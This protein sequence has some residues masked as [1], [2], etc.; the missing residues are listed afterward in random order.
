MPAL[1]ALSGGSLLDRGH[2][3]L[4]QRELVID[5]VTAR[6]G[7]EY[8]WGVHVAFSEP[9]R[10]GRSGAGLAREWVPSDACWTG[11]DRLVLEIVDSLERQSDIGDALWREARDRLSEP[12][13]LEIMMLAG[14][15]R[16]ISY[17]TVALR[18]PLEP[19]AARFPK[20]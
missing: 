14:F 7:S 15:Y 9:R 6:C 5:R 17:L 2:L 16:M 20:R 8:E 1:R 10:V 19:Y 3:T 18:L 12:A 11:D 13:L 4:R